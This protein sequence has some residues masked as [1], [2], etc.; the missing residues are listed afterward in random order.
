MLTI[1][2]LTGMRPDLLA[3]TLEAFSSRQPDLW[4]SAIKVV[5]HNTGDRPTREVLDEYEWDDRLTLHG[6]LRSIA[7][8]SEQLLAVAD[9]AGQE[10][11]LRLEDDWEATSA[12]WWNDAVELLKKAGQVR[13]RRSDEKV[14]AT[15]RVTKQQIIWKQQPSGHLWSRSAHYTHNPSLM[16]T[17]DAV[18]LSGYSDEI[19]AAR[20]YLEAGWATAQLVPGVFRHLG[21][22]EQGLS[23]KWSQDGR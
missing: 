14:L 1:G 9:D 15:H 5:V 11:F 2:V 21:H 22:R 4:Q 8:A 18:S 23:L 7:E 19:D 6:E 12:A 20:R 3:Q 13:L 17:A 16:R 10:Y